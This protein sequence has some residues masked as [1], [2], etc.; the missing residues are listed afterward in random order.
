MKLIDA[1]EILRRPVSN[2]ASD[3]R[4]YL[5]CGFTPLH[6]ETFLGAHLRRLRPACRVKVNTGLFG[7]LAGNLERL[8]S[9]EYDALAV[10]IEWQDLDSRLG[11]RTL[12]GWQAEK[13]PGIVTTA[14]QTLGRLARDLQKIATILP[15]TVCLPTL[16]L[17]PLFY[18][19]VRRSSAYELSLRR[20]LAAFADAISSGGKVSVVSGQLLDEMS[21]LVDRFDLR[22][23]ITQGFPY[24]VSHASVVG[25]LLA[26]LIS[27]PEPKKGLITDLDDTLWSGILGEVGVQGICWHLEEHAQ[28][29]GIY[30]QFL[31]SLAGAGVMIA[32]ASK[33][34]AAIVDQAFERE[35][36]LLA[37]ASVFPIEA[38]WRQKSE[39][40]RHILKKWN[41]LAQSAVFVDD[42]PIE[43]AEVK[44]AFPEMECLRFPKDDYPA[45]L[46]FLNHLRD[47][48]AKATVSEEDVLRLQSLRESSAF[49]ES[50][51]GAGTSLDDFLQKAEGR[52]TFASGKS[53]EDERAF[54]LVNKTNQ[55]N[56]NGRRY[57]RAA[58]TKLLNDGE[59]CVITASYED[60]FGKLGRIAVLIG[61]MAHRRFLLESWVMSCRA[62]SRRIEFHCLQ[63]LF[64]KF[65]VD[66]IVFDFQTTGSNGPL[67]EF[68]QQTLDGPVEGNSKLS[69][70]SFVKKAPKMP[71]HVEEVSAVGCQ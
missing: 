23:E 70:S 35:D 69:R 28:I 25:E 21:P 29:H 10:I 50:A 52:L 46:A 67:M 60:K 36:L 40:V 65:P 57:D 30:Q 11:L 32:A 4:I 37:K 6:V 54:E 71:H 43:V 8:R 64:E 1:L 33:N 19:G 26:G 61:R 55:F 56:L 22:S 2:E 62:F 38:H 51:I 3:L 44:S 17:P 18:S 53:A 5:A 48:F 12:G 13:L 68:L 20:D 15:T 39:S 58:W 42:S 9:E 63:H 41:V 27:G 66:E 16:P 31:A 45:F 47:S 7:D 59:T 24:K 14:K 49:E 34:D